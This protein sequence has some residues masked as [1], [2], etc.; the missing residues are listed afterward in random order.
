MHVV[1]HSPN[2]L[3]LLGFRTPALTPSQNLN[4]QVREPARV[5]L[6]GPG[7]IG[8]CWGSLPNCLAVTR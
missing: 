4:G 8:L 2:C 6:K 5:F 7:G 1:R 3:I